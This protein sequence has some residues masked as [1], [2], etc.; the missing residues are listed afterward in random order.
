MTVIG[1]G[2]VGCKHPMLVDPVTPPTPVVAGLECSGDAWA[3]GA[4]PPSGTEAW[5]Q[6]QLPS[7]RWLKQGP[8]LEWHTNGALAVESAYQE[9]VLQGPFL[10]W[11]PD[12]T[13]ST[14]GSYLDGTHTGRWEWYYPNGSLSEEG[15]YVH[16]LKQ[17]LW[18]Q[19]S[20]NGERIEAS[21][22]SD[23]LHGLWTHFDMESVPLRQRV[24]QEGRL[25]SQ[26]GL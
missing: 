7:G 20:P 8:A 18:I 23:Q 24:Y 19:R 25:V 22:V 10:A 13:P 3:M 4:S 15:T 21:Y 26:Q 5:C 6:V 2:G 1:L 16:G 11:Y 14:R 9:G 17:G 12:G